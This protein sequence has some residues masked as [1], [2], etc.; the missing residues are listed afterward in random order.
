[1]TDADLLR[2]ADA[3]TTQIGGPLWRLWHRAFYWARNWGG[4]DD[5]RVHRAARALLERRL[6][7]RLAEAEARAERAEGRIARAI[8]ALSDRWGDP[9]DRIREARD[10][11]RGEGLAP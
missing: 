4:R 1:M 2:A 3:E 8:E 11:L 5:A 7:E 10:E 9:G 6:R